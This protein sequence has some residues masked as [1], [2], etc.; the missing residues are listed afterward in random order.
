MRGKWA[1][2][3]HTGELVCDLTIDLTIDLH[4]INLG[5]LYSYLCTQHAVL[6]HQ[7][8]LLHLQR[9]LALPTTPVCI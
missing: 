2:L 6:H 5:L 1:F 8:L 9:V 3:E 7:L 4:S